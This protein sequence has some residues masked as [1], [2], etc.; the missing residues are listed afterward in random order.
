MLR[1]TAALLLVSMSI[2]TAGAQ[3][4]PDFEIAKRHYLA[5]KNAVTAGDY[6]TAIREY[7]LAY[8][9]TKD[10]TLFKQIGAAYEAEGKKTE[11]AVYYRRYLVEMK[12]NSDADEVRARL[13]SLEGKPAEPSK[14]AS[15]LPPRS[16]SEP[17]APPKLPPPES[18]TQAPAEMK[19]TQPDLPTYADEGFRWQRTAAWISVG[20]AAVGVTTGSVLATSALAREDDIR[21]LENYRDPLTGQPRT[22]SGATKD[23]YKNKID[24]GNRLQDFATAAF[25][26]AGACAAAATLFFILDA[27]RSVPHERLSMHPYL[28]WNGGGVRAAW[29]F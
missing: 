7:I 15:P 26:G 6:E 24:E 28:D 4:K 22:Y 1:A 18:P 16:G 14:A 8:D 20:L 3:S 13:V 27:T 17:A 21:Q 19:L 23:D 25:I 5:G 2:G 9:I 10:P 12:N 11:A 29:E